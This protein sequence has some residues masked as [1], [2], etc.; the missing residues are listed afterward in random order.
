MNGFSA[1]IVTLVPVVLT[2]LSSPALSSIVT[3]YQRIIP[4]C[5]AEGRGSHD[6]WIDL[7]SSVLAWKLAGIPD[8]ARVKCN[9][10]LRH[11]NQLENVSI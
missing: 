9:H 11:K 4:F 5:S 6:N 8:G 1:A 7:E 10:K 2:I 3:L